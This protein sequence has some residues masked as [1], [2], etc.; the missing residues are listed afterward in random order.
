MIRPKILLSVFAALLAPCVS[1]A[2]PA[3]YYLCPLDIPIYLSAN[4]GEIRTNRFHTGI[5]IKTEGVVGKPLRAAADGHIARVTVAPGGYGRALYIAHPNGTTT[6]YAHMDRFT[7]EIEAY[8]K[9]ERYRLRRSDIDLFPDAARF[10]VKKGDVIGAAGNSGSSSGP[11]LHFEVRRSSD[12]RSINPMPQ[13]WIATAQPDALPPRIVRLHHIDVDTL[14]GVPVHSR[15]RSYDV[16]AGSDG[17]YSLVR[18]SPLKAGPTSYFVI[19]A[20]DRRGDVA[21]TFGIRRATLSVDGDERVVFDKDG[22]LFEQ[23]RD[24]CASVLYDVQRRARGGNEAV[25]LAVR[26]GNRLGMYKKAVNRGALVFGG[27]KADGMITSGGMVTAAAPRSVVITVEDDAGNIS[28]LAF[29]VEP[30]TARPAPARPSGR[31]TP[32]YGNFIHFADGMAVSIPREALWEPIFYS[33]EI[34]PAAVAPRTDS[35]RPLSPVYRTGDG[36]GALRSAMRID[37]AAADLPTHLRSRAGLA[38]VSENGSLSWAGGSWAG[39]SVN[40]SSRDFG[41]FCV[42]ADTV[43]PVVGASFGEGADLSG[44][45]S[46]TLTASDNFSGIASFNGAIDGQWIIFE[47]QAS[48]GRYVHTFD[49]DRLPLGTTHTLEFTVRD[50]AGNTTTIRRTFYK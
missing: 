29:A 5:D 27:G 46:V 28:T 33:Q 32:L 43:A 30:D 24:A 11:H 21:N 44:A 13:G 19:E 38:R 12:S 1:S 17:V 39:G 2:Q 3:D 40:G 25:M 41:M 31:P 22:V 36:T 16:K 49:P 8:L 37:I 10:P 14:G 47:R 9:A 35:I 7:R 34:V 26:D 42:V 18:T 20:T 45:S 15:A 4:F 50:G 23:V 48:R 6:V